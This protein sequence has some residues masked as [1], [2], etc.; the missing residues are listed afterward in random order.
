MQMVIATALDG[1]ELRFS[2]HK[3]DKSMKKILK[4]KFKV[5]CWP[6]LGEARGWEKRYKRKSETNRLDNTFVTELLI[7]FFTTHH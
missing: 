2:Y 7:F 4:M 3:L 6:Y 5:Q 1:I